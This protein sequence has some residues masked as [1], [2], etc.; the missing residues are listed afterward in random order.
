MLS[1]SPSKQVE[2]K[3]SASDNTETK[4]Q[5]ETAS[6]ELR[7]LSLNIAC[8]PTI[9]GRQINKHTLRPNHRR[10][11]EI[12][13]EIVQWNKKYLASES[14]ED[15]IPPLI[16]CLQ[17]SFDQKAIDILRTHLTLYYPH[18]MINP[19]TGRINVGSG[20]S[21]FSTF[22]IIDSG[23]VPFK[24][25]MLGEESLANKGV[26]WVDLN[27]NDK[28]F[29]TVYNTHLHA[30]GA[31]FP[32]WSKSYGGTTSKRRGEQMQ[33]IC[34]LSEEHKKISTKKIQGLTLQR[35][36]EFVTGDVNVGIQDPRRQS[37]T[38]TGMSNNGFKE[39]D[40]KYPGQYHLFH[41]FKCPTPDNFL[42]VKEAIPQQKGAKK[43]INPDLL[44][45]AKD[46]N[47][48]IG[49]SIASEVLKKS[50]AIPERSI[51]QGHEATGKVIDCLAYNAEQGAN[52]SFR[53]EIIGDFQNS[54]DHFAVFGI[55]GLQ[56]P[57]EKTNK[58]A[59]NKHN[60]N[61]P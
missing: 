13:D 53:T 25:N 55:F 46:K 50:V 54:T 27:I 42:E 59:A 28:Q 38:S 58:Q 22:P 26:Q 6:F 35:I 33:M 61:N 15:K 8:L 56:S 41:R 21:I 40:I 48:F 47:L 17:E 39:R 18:Q 19:G 57:K 52:C 3:N 44:K 11:Q 14:K 37:S 45:K 34:D 16:I 23:F 31:L 51:I 36:V 30:G 2:E 24:N 32:K 7:I 5:P 1:K 29:V 10:A 49:T 43:Q 60:K 12:A 20:L 4:L 9:F